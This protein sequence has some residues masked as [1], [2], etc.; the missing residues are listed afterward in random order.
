MTVTTTH[1]VINTGGGSA[2]L[3]VLILASIGSGTF[4]V[5]AAS[6]IAGRTERVERHRDRM[7]AAADAFLECALRFVSAARE[8]IDALKASKPSATLLGDL[9]DRA[10]ETNA[11]TAQIWLLYGTSSRTGNHVRNVMPGIAAVLRPLEKTPADV[12]A[13]EAAIPP[14]GVELEVFIDTSRGAI[15]EMGNFWRRRSS[16]QRAA[17]AST[18]GMTIR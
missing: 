18:Y 2:P 3:W 4:G 15:D 12:A 9:R 10:E 16:R 7:I 17:S 13:A 8:T 14:I 11:R 5:V 6:W 1:L